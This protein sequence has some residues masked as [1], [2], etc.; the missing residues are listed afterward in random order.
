M[1]FIAC[2]TSTSTMEARA[3]QGQGTVDHRRPAS[4]MPHSPPAST[5]PLNDPAWTS[6]PRHRQRPAPGCAL[7]TI[8]VKLEED[9]Q[10]PVD[11]DEQTV[12]Y[13]SLVEQPPSPAIASPSVTQNPLLSSLATTRSSASRAAVDG[14]VLVVDDDALTG[15]IASPSERLANEGRHAVIV[16]K[17]H[18][19]DVYAFVSG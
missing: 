3:G 12:T 9:A 6:R 14:R 19:E 11:Q 7:C 18:V 1:H 2:E 15:W 4:A 10:Q 13:T 5:Q 8:L 16:F 17:R